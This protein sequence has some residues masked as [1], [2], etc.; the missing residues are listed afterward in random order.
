MS[1][2]ASQKPKYCCWVLNY[3]CMFKCKMC[4]IWQTAAHDE[5]TTLTDKKKFIDSLQGFVEKDFEFHLAGGE[6][7]L[8]K[9]ITTIVRHI[10]DAGFRSNIVTNG[11]LVD[12]AMARSLAESGLESLTFSLDGSTAETHDYL[13]GK[14]GSFDQIHAAIQ[15]IHAKKIPLSTSIIMLINACNIDEVL[16]L[17]EWTEKMPEVAMISFQVITQPFS[18]ERNDEWFKKSP[19]AFLWPKNLRKTDKVLRALYERK[20]SGA[21]IGNNANQFLAFQRYFENP[22]R[23]LKKIKCRMG[24]YEFHV[25]P[26]GKVFFC[27]FTDPIGTIKTDSLPDLWK[28]DNTMRIRNDVYACKKNCHIM[29]NCFYEDESCD[30]RK[31]SLLKRLKESFLKE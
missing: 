10:K 13:R 16:P 29:I 30:V 28:S 26:Y 7:L 9:N 23:F 19:D 5:E 22:D 12:E 27:C 20:K 31:P 8:E 24:D 21:K 11:W 2:D 25:D 14:A 3:R 4:Y 6:P 15:M 18:R 1:W 17:L